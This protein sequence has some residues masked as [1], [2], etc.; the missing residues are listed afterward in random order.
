[1]PE[2]GRSWEERRV[3]VYLDG[4]FGR[5]HRKLVSAIPAGFGVGRRWEDAERPLE[6]VSERVEGENPALSRLLFVEE[7]GT[8]SRVPAPGRSG[9]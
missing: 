3:E 6:R 2:V 9:R 5:E 7:G 4:V 1:M 8:C